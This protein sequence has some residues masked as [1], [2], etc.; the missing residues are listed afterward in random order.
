MQGIRGAEKIFY[1]ILLVFLFAFFV[2]IKLTYP[3]V[4]ISSRRE[5]GTKILRNSGQNIFSVT[6]SGVYFNKK[7]FFEII[8]LNTKCKI[9]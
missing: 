4:L 8:I 3:D 2:A 1:P 5:G 6:L 9:M 7:L